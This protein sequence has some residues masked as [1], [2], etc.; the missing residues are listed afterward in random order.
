MLKFIGDALV[1]LFPSPGEGLA[2][3]LEIMLVIE[4]YNKHRIAKDYEVRT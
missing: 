4:E 3:G 2:A 1:A